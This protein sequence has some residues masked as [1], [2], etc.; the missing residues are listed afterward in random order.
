MQKGIGWHPLQCYSSIPFSPQTG[1]RKSCPQEWTHQA[2][3]HKRISRAMLL[4]HPTLLT[5]VPSA[6]FPLSSNVSFSPFIPSLLLLC[7]WML[8]GLLSWAVPARGPSGLDTTKGTV[9]LSTL[10]KVSERRK[11]VSVKLIPQKQWLGHS[12]IFSTQSLG[13]SKCFEW[14]ASQLSVLLMLSA[15][16][17]AYCTIPHWGA[18]D[19]LAVYL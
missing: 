9:S 15:L 14:T 16:I 3:L 6:S 18:S 4:S 5:P 10:H 19:F 11:W 1:R 8:A 17:V 2:T 7:L 13:L 12:N